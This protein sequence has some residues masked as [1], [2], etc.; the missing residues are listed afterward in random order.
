MAQLF[1]CRIGA[2]KVLFS[3]MGLQ[4]LQKY[5]EARTLLN[6]IY[7]YMESDEF[8]PQQELTIE[9]LKSIVS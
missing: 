5:T 1:E 8:A 4:D 7:R 9:E 2:G 6:S 3:S